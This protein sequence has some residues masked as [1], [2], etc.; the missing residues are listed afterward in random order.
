MNNNSDNSLRRYFTFALYILAALYL[1]LSIYSAYEIGVLY[2]QLLL[3]GCFIILVYASNQRLAGRLD[4][5]SSSSI[6]GKISGAQIEELRENY[7]RLNKP[8]SAKMEVKIFGEEVY[9]EIDGDT[10]TIVKGLSDAIDT[11][12]KLKGLYDTLIYVRGED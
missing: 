4:V 9:Y 2:S 12:P 3:T 1:G 6:K 5:L 8:Y 10:V 11:D 7:R